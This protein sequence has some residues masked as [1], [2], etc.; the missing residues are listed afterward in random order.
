MLRN[1]E[2]RF[3]AE[4]SEYLCCDRNR[5][6]YRYTA[7]ICKL[8]PDF[9]RQSLSWNGACPECRLAEQCIQ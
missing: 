2:Y 8:W 9:S 6:K 4:F 3:F 1:G 7:S 5:T